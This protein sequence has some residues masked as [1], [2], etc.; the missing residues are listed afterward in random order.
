MG[1]GLILP[2]TGGCEG[3]ARA[4]RQAG[5][6]SACI[7]KPRCRPPGYTRASWWIALKTAEIPGGISAIEG[8]VCQNLCAART[9]FDRECKIVG[10]S[11]RVRRVQLIP[12]QPR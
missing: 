1:G 4:Q 10:V 11:V 5:H 12:N 3:S 9:I 7:R 6:A 8:P 2:A